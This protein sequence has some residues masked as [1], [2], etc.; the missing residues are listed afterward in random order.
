MTRKMFLGGPFKAL[1]DAESH[2]MGH[3]DIDKYSSIIDFFE[4]RD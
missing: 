2:V 3:A 4:A 1:V